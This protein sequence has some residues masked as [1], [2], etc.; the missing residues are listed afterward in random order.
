M[1]SKEFIV[2]AFLLGLALGAG[3]SLVFTFAG[4]EPTREVGALD[5]PRRT[6]R[7]TRTREERPAR[8]DPSEQG[9]P[10]PDGRDTGSPS[11]SS[12]PAVVR[13]AGAA[14][15]QGTIEGR[16]RESGGLPLPDVEVRGQVDGTA[17]G[18]ANNTPVWTTTNAEGHYSLI[19]AR[20]T[21][22]RVT[23]HHERLHLLPTKGSPDR[24]L[25]AGD[26]MDF[27][28]SD[29]VS[30]PINVRMP[31]G[32]MAASA[33][34]EIKAAV[35]EFLAWSPERSTVLLSIG[36]RSIQANWGPLR[37]TGLTSC[38]RVETMFEN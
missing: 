37:G 35:P 21:H 7:E 23:A 2:L 1:K 29:L 27:V 3:A 19:V 32:S 4:E 15:E 24:P 9:V 31:D 25:L 30:V 20:N 13:E 6:E 8:E 10:L 38:A 26:R 28:A 33:T 16:I 12:R 22:Y 18:T 17:E 14:T 5:E 34:I 11:P 36:W